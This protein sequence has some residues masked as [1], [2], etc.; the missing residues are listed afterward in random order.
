M[1]AACLPTRLRKVSRVRHPTRPALHRQNHRTPN[2]PSPA[3]PKSR[4]RTTG[5]T[6]AKPTRTPPANAYVEVLCLDA[7][8]V[9]VRDSKNPCP[10]L[11]FT[12][13]EW[14]TFTT[15][16]HPGVHTYPPKP[17]SNLRRAPHLLVPRIVSH[18][19][20]LFTEQIR[21]RAKMCAGQ[22]HPLTASST[23][24]RSVAS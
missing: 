7:G 9:E 6:A 19:T 20:H 24:A 10:S 17:R 12:P 14:D 13:T 3:P 18:A 5:P 15:R 4:C 16:I 8:H 1:E 22:C 2:R 11:I 21:S 23:G